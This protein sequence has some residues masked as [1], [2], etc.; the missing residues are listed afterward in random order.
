[1]PYVT[2]HWFGW[3]QDLARMFHH[4]G[5]MFALFKCTTV[6]LLPFKPSTVFHSYFF[7]PSP[8]FHLSHDS[9][10][11]HLL[12]VFQFSL[13]RCGSIFSQLVSQSH[14]LIKKATLSRNLYEIVYTV[15]HTF[16]R[17]NTI[18]YMGDKMKTYVFAHLIITWRR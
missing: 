7:D 10:T 5:E 12:L 9:F 2:F 11:G 17:A 8:V 18:N 4:V 15:E 3:R 13:S 1:M 6:F 16:N 14:S